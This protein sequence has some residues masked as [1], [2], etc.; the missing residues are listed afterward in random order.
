MILR[1][2]NSP[3][4][5]GTTLQLLV[6]IE[7]K[8]SSV[9]Y[10]P[11]GDLVAA[12]N[13][14]P[15]NS[16]LRSAV[17]QAYDYTRF[18][19]FGI[20]MTDKQLFCIKREGHKCLISTGISLFEE[21]SPLTAAAAM[22]CM[23]LLSEAA[24]RGKQQ[25]RDDVC[26]SERSYQFDELFEGC[27]AGGD[28]PRILGSGNFQVLEGRVAG[29]AAAVKLADL[30]KQ[31][32]AEALFRHEAEVYQRLAALQGVCVPR[33]LAYGHL[34]GGQYFLATSLEGASLDSKQGRAMPYE[35]VVRSTMHAL[36][37]IHEHGVLHGDLALRNVVLAAAGDKALL[38]DFGISV[39]LSGPQAEAAAIG[40]PHVAKEQERQQLLAELCELHG[41]GPD[42]PPCSTGAAS[43]PVAAIAPRFSSG[44]HDT[45]YVDGRKEEEVVIG[46]RQLD[47]D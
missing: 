47:V 16:H 37:Q 8:Y 11:D 34:D 2:N 5:D 21:A 23:L 24:F 14:S 10:L 18:T 3:N 15:P 4:F 36:D 41:G 43:W 42:V 25:H 1:R 32:H 12:Y 39:V 33:L 46:D 31:P 6:P 44:L 13:I 26:T 38:L 17:N 40:E 20:L 9:F 35:A 27:G 19:D 29:R 22:Y 7:L 28:F 30:S 45:G